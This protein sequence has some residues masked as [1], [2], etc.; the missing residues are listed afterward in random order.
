LLYLPVLKSIE[1]DNIGPFFN[2][3]SPLVSLD[4]S[5]N[6]ILSDDGVGKSSILKAI[7]VGLASRR[8]RTPRR[9]AG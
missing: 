1:L 7:A 9:Q 6:V 4:P 2:L 3:K 8:V 5:W